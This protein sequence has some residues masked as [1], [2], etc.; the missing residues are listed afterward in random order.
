MHIISCDIANKSLATSIIYYNLNLSNDIKVLYEIYLDKKS[1]LLSGFNVKNKHE[2]MKEILKCYILL[3]DDIMELNAKKIKIISLNVVDLIPG[4]KVC[5]TDIIYRTDKLYNYL[6]LVLDPQ[7]LQLENCTFLMELQMAQNVQSNV[8]ASQIMY[9]FM[10]YQNFPKDN[11][12][13]IG[14]SL[15]N[16]VNIGGGID[17]QHA[18]FMEKYK[19]NYA[20][21]KVHIKYNFLKLL[22]YLNCKHMIADIKKSNIDDI[23]DS[24]LQGLAPILL[25]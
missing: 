17:S 3:L 23:G 14:A 11:I 6:H 10:K 5:D 1:T 18:E 22:D 24:V 12:K 8:I 7:I 25:N 4:K 21:N 13:L 19:T 15:K 20:A 9:H 16:K 2:N